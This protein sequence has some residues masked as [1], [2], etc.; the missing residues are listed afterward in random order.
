M[1]DLGVWAARQVERLRLEWVV[2]ELVEV[3]LEGEFL[4]CPN[5][6]QALDE[7]LRS[8]V[9]LGM[10]KPPLA[11]GCKLRRMSMNAVTLENAY[12]LQRGT[13]QIQR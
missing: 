5:A 1:E 2:V 11:D 8:A 4:V 10:V 9:T 13:N 3:A 6:L 12:V 7:F